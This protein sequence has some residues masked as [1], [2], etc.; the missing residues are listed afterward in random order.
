MFLKYAGAEV[1]RRCPQ[2]R[3]LLIPAPT[4]HQGHW[5]QSLFFLGTAIT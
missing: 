3:M 1:K 2:N 4:R 5:E